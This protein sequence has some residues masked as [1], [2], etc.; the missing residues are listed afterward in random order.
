MTAWTVN[1]EKLAS[2]FE[3]IDEIDWISDV[4]VIHYKDHT[5][6]QGFANFLDRKKI[7]GNCYPCD[8]YVLPVKDAFNIQ[9]RYF[10][11]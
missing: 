9:I 11:N 2:P 8:Q 6:H 10:S 1:D 5:L 3:A 7:S 4:I